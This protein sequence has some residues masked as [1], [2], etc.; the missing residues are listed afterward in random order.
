MIADF[1]AFSAKIAQ[2]RKVAASPKLA[3]AGRLSAL[4]RHPGWKSLPQRAKTVADYAGTA[5]AVGYG[6]PLAVNMA[7]GEEPSTAAGL[8]LSTLAAAPLLVSRRARQ[9][10]KKNLRAPLLM[11]SGL[12]TAQRAF[13]GHSMLRPNQ[14]HQAMEK[15][16]DSFIADG[17]D[18]V[19]N[20]IDNQ[21]NSLAGRPSMVN[22]LRQSV[23]RPPFWAD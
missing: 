14:V 11:A 17:I 8:G 5:A 9:F 4:L 2:Q 10:A 20:L 18:A 6:V 15:E 16:R 21:G 3:A 1:A 19:S 7:T 12:D 13:M 23:S 22:S